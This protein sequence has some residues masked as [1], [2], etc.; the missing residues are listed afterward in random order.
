M[1]TDE[2]DRIVVMAYQTVTGA[3]S[4]VSNWVLSSRQL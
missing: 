2:N 4:S 3:A 1:E